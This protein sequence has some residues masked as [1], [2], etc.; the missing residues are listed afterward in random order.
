MTT[1]SPSAAS[2]PTKEMQQALEADGEKLRQLTGGDHGPLQ[3]FTCEVCDGRGYIVHRVTVYEHGCGFPHD[4]SEERQ[5]PEC[6]GYGEFIGP[7]EGDAVPA[8]PRWR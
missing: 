4:D 1:P 6:S 3:L 5:C 2:C 7:R 8:R